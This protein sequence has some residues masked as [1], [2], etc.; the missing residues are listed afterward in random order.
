[1]LTERMRGL[2]KRLLAMRPPRVLLCDENRALYR[3]ND[4][5]GDYVRR[6]DP[7]EREQF[8]ALAA[9][10]PQELNLTVGIRNGD[11]E[12]I[13]GIAGI[14]VTL[15]EE[16]AV[17]TYDDLR[18]AGAKTSLVTVAAALLGLRMEQMHELLRGPNFAGDLAGWITPQEAAA[19]V[20]HAIEAENRSGS[21]PADGSGKANAGIWRR[22]NRTMLQRLEDGMQN[23][24]REMAITAW[25]RRNLLE[26]G[27][28]EDHEPY[29]TAF[30]R[31][32]QQ[33]RNA[34][35]QTLVAV[36][37]GI[38]PSAIVGDG[39][40]IARQVQV[41][42]GAVIGNGVRLGDAAVIG[43]GATVHDRARVEAGSAVGEDAVIAEDAV[44]HRGCKV[45]RS[46]FVGNGAEMDDHAQ[47]GDEASLGRKSRLHTHAE[48][49]PKAQIGA[50][51]RI[52]NR[53]LI[54]AGVRIGNDA[55]IGEQAKIQTTSIGNDSWVPP[56]AIVDDA[57]AGTRYAIKL[58]RR[59]GNSK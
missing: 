49:R 3:T 48:V 58:E 1:M 14:A 15:H 44:I 39:V 7:L 27:T 22:I 33:I 32:R 37:A 16:A 55:I 8:V 11:G 41:R 25:T 43:E 59:P 45:G 57:G 40:T 12:R 26:E 28:D 50:N 42:D 13:A 54:D 53:A 52:F 35:P 20:E 23:T 34:Y 2:A 38:A 47:L 36:D 24:P 19:A 21:P 51:T 5:T 31:R 4:P 10:S 6:S 56:E 17:R 18:R 29:V 9:D 30:G 46:A